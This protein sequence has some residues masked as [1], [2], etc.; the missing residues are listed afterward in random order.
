MVWMMDEYSCIDEFN[1]LGFIIGKLFVLGGLYGCEI[2][3]VKGVI[4]CICEV[5]KKCGIDIKGVCVVV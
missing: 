2:V 1:L 3:I 4:I 5:V